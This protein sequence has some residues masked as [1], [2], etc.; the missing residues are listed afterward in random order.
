MKPTTTAG[1]IGAVVLFLLVAYAVRADDPKR[2][3]FEWDPNPLGEGVVGYRLQA[4]PEVGGTGFSTTT[5]NTT[6]SL[7]LGPGKWRVEVLAYD[8]AGATSDPSPPKWVT[9]SDAGE[10]VRPSTVIW[11]RVLV[12]STITT[13]V[14]NWVE[15]LP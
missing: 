14:S 13:T 15:V 4:S 6:A 12:E 10:V 3:R 11:L 1:I 5:T 8:D 7:P 9:I 2:I